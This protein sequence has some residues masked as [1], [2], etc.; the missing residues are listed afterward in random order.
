MLHMIGLEL[1]F[2]IGVVAANNPSKDAKQV[3]Y[4]I[5]G[6]FAL[7]VAGAWVQGNGLN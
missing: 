6:L 7:F 4:F 3:G 1:A 2:L 5:A